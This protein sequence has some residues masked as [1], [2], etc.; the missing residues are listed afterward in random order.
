[1]SPKEKISPAEKQVKEWN[2]RFVKKTP[3]NLLEWLLENYPKQ[4]ALAF[5]LSA[6]DTILLHM[7]SSIDSDRKKKFRVFVLDTGRLHEES[8][9]TL[10]NCR[11]RYGIKIELYFPQNSAVEQLV[12][13]KGIY[14]FYESLENR[15][16]CCFIRKVEPLGRG[17]AGDRC[18]DHWPTSR[19]VSK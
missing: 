8:Y 13:N 19:A 12:R 5:S 6:E 16:E 14:S 18:L 2:E 10:E 11:N 1:M 17:F 3:Q 15:K 9:E 7:L 4:V